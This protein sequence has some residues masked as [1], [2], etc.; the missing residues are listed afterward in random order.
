MLFFCIYIDLLHKIFFKLSWVSL[1]G[2]E[3]KL[4]WNPTNTL[5]T[6]LQL[7]SSSDSITILR[8]V[9]SNSYGA[10]NMRHKVARAGFCFSFCTD[11]L[12]ESSFLENWSTQRK[13]TVIKVLCD[14]R[15]SDFQEKEEKIL[16]CHL[17]FVER[18]CEI[19]VF[20]HP[21]F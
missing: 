9:T 1:A 2:F 12:H 21:L 3:L 4:A 5:H 18:K 11:F 7:Y 16:L 6:Y 8:A 10:P 14:F 17:S 13:Y 20:E 15:G 19:I